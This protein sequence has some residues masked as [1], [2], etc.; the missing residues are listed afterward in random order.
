[1][2]L[3][4]ELLIFVSALLLGVPAAGAGQQAAPPAGQQASGQS[5]QQSQPL[6]PVS[7]EEPSPTAAGNEAPAATEDAR[8]FG[9]AESYSVRSSGIMR[10]YFIPSF[11]F[12]EMGDSNFAISSGSHSFETTNTLVGRLDYKKVGR[13]AQTTAEYIGGAVIYNHHSELNS[14]IQQFGITESYQGRR[15]SFLLDDRATY[16]PESGYGYGGFGYGGALG[17]D[18]G[19]AAGSNLSDLNP[20]IN[21]AGSL[22]TGRGSRVLNTS[23]V[24][25]QYLAGARS[26][27][28]LAVS[29]GFLHFTTPGFVGS[30]NGT[31]MLG[32]SHS[33]S[34]RDYIGLNYAYGVFKFPSNGTSFN[35]NILQASYGHRISGRMSMTLAGGPQINVIKNP[36][37]GSSTPSS[38]TAQASMDYRAR[39]GDMTAYYYR[40]TTNGGGVLN[41]AST[42]SVSMA[43]STNLWH[44]WSGSLGPGYSHNKS[45]PQTTA[46][47]IQSTFDAEFVN[48]SLG[49]A[50]GRYTSM[51]ITYTFQTQASNTSP[52]LSGGCGVSLQRHVIGIG[53]DFHP[54]QISIE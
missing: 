7:A 25:V 18:L 22:L 9:G 54:R 5:S 16:L 26:S 10:G 37:T 27:M 1:M 3:R 6:A 28:T 38:W 2:R 23:V 43:W 51:F 32:Y 17:I 48:A 50:M 14:T 21:P 36:V 47:H 12:S 34:A 11:Q 45:L 8:S 41:G 31:V 49:R 40:T 33:F 52:C 44:K 20:T 29:Y 42:D 39:K 46:S 35:T 19:G 15:W 4:N 53:F 30:R 24:Q 13:R